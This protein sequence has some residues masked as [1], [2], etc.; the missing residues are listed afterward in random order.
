MDEQYSIVYVDKPGQSEWGAIGGGISDFNYEI[1]G[2]LPDF[3]PGHQ[4]YFLTKKL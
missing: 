3:P 2:E 4:R 1:Y